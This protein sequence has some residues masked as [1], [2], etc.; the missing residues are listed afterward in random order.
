MRRLLLLL[1]VRGWGPSLLTQRRIGGIHLTPWL[2]LLLLL[3]WWPLLLVLRRGLLLLTGHRAATPLHLLLWW[4][5]PVAPTPTRLTP[6]IK[7]RE[8]RPHPSPLLWRRLHLSV[9]RLL[10]VLWRLPVLRRLQRRRL[11]VRGVQLVRGRRPAAVLRRR[12]LVGRRAPVLLRGAVG[13]A[14]AALQRGWGATPTPGLV[15]LRAPGALRALP[16]EVGL[17]AAGAAAGSSGGG[18]AARDGVGGWRGGVGFRGGLAVVS[19]GW[20]GSE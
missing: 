16:R 9:R 17:K 4:R 6:S 18:A 2:L 14:H 1:L 7:R 12:L 19:L 15:E 20:V 5:G 3:W 8:T 11:A 13:V 10:L